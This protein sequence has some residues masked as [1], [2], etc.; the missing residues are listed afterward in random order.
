MSTKTPPQ[1]LFVCCQKQHTHKTTANNTKQ[2][3]HNALC[4]LSQTAHAQDHRKQ[5]KTPPQTLCVCCHKQ[6]THTH[7]HTTHTFTNI[8][9]KNGTKERC[10]GERINKLSHRSMN[11]RTNITNARTRKMRI[12]NKTTANK[13]NAT[14]NNT[15]KTTENTSLNKTF[16]YFQRQRLMAC[17][18]QSGFCCFCHTSALNIRV[19]YRQKITSRTIKN[20]SN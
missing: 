15:N 16:A 1:T 6:H 9:H 8:N 18:M 20:T 7:T 19:L 2:H 10:T 13:T 4:L 17:I 5:H 12:R 14:A 11:K 3:T